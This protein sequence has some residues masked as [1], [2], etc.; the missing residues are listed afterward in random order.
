MRGIELLTH[1]IGAENGGE[2]RTRL[3]NLYRRQRARVG[4]RDARAVVEIEDEA[5]KPWKV[6]SGG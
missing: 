4:E 5:R 3:E 6:I 2:W 1:R